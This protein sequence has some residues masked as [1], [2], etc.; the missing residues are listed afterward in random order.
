MKLVADLAVRLGGR[1]L[2]LR[3]VD[4]DD[5]QAVVGLYTEVFG[6]TP[7]EGW[8]T[9]KYGPHGLNG[10]AMGLWDRDAGLVAHYA[11]FPRTLVWRGRRVV[12]V[13]IGDVMVAP[14]ARG[15]LTRQGPFYHVC[16]TVF[17]LWVGKDRPY[18]LAYGFPNERHLR[19]GV[20]LGLY[21]DLGVIVRLTWLAEEPLAPVTGYTTKDLHEPP[22][23][24]VERAW[25]GMQRDFGSLI[26]G[27]RDPAY[28][29]ARF[30]RRPGVEHR[31][32]VVRRH[33]SR[34][35]AVAVW[36]VAE[37]TVRWLDYVGPRSFLP[38]VAALL[39]QRA[40]ALGVTTVETWASPRARADL[41]ATGAVESGPAARFAVAQRS[42]CADGALTE[43]G[44][45]L[46]GD[47]D[48]L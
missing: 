11:A 6:E 30:Q 23:L 21:H 15:L 18:A 36:R 32:L 48:F 9:W 26:L 7:P 13:Q 31:Y 20:R 8:Y 42:D 14:R 28:L 4:R 29:G 2:V 33:W 44:W 16:S 45:W 40:H 3:P 37:E 22:T 17:A 1:E 35:F 12:A 39:R 47:T 27:Q 10:F 19:L 41:L 46:A 25:R 34:Q 43:A 24:L 38:A 5:A